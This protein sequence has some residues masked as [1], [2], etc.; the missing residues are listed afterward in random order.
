MISIWEMSYRG[1]RYLFFFLSM[2]NS[3]KAWSIYN[4]V[5]VTCK[6]FLGF[7]N[8]KY[9]GKRSWMDYANI[10]VQVIQVTIKN[11]KYNKKLK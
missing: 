6:D 7:P 11:N 9:S 2:L 1:I 10:E 4:L 3:C 5:R 8:I